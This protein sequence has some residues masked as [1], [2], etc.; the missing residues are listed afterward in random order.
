MLLPWGHANLLCIVAIL[1]DGPRRESN[2][3]RVPLPS[4]HIARQLPSRIKDVQCVAY[5]V[6]SRL[7][8]GSRLRL[9]TGGNRLKI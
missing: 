7:K 5:A 2:K 4:N 9:S 3:R 8:L 1:T 6:S